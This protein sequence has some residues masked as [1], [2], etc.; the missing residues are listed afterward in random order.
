VLYCSEA[1]NFCLL[2]VLALLLLV[3]LQLL[4]M[5]AAAVADRQTQS[6]AQQCGFSCDKY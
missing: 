1:Y 5:A 3:L 4:L 6:C 2:T